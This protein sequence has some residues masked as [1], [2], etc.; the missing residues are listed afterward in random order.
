MKKL[1]LKLKL[2][3]NLQKINQYFYLVALTGTLTALL[4]VSM[5]LYKNFYQ[6]ITQSNEVLILQEK[7]ASETVSLKKFNEV[8]ERIDSKKATRTLETIINPF[9]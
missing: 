1:K 2:K 9:D 6:T 4:V 5:F 7:V 8:I 3:L